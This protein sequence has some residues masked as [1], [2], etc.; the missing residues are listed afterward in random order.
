VYVRSKRAGERVMEHLRPLYA[1]LRLKVNEDKSPVAR[2]WDRKFLGYSFWV[3]KEQEI[4]RS[5]A[6]KALD[7]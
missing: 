6:P 7:G 1:K 3:D 4:K 5:V 2:A